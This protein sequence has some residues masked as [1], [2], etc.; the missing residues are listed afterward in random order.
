LASKSADIVMARA[1]PAVFIS[2]AHLDKPLVLRVVEFLRGGGLNV[3]VDSQS[4]PYGDDWRDTLST[5]IEKCE[6]VMLFWTAAASLSKW[7][8]R[9]WE[10]ALEKGKRV[11]PTLL[12]NTPLPP[13]LGRLQAV[14]ALRG[15]FAAPSRTIDE[16]IAELAQRDDLASEQG[17]AGPSTGAG[18]FDVFL[19]N[20]PTNRAEVASSPRSAGSGSRLGIVV[21]SLA[22]VGVL[23]WFLVAQ[24]PSPPTGQIDLPSTAA[25][26]PVDRASAPN[27]IPTPG[28][29]EAASAPASA[30]GASEPA[31]GVGEGSG[32]VPASAPSGS[33]ARESLPDAPA[34]EPGFWDQISPVFVGWMALLGAL[35]LS[36]LWWQVRRSRARRIVDE[37]LSA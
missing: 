1:K 3:F 6:R 25:S 14:T 7:V 26:A 17:D 30:D 28:P 21:A 27:V 20:A 24:R 2:Y 35:G 34:M 32:G 23:T 16:V 15:M 36:Y 29:A 4:I 22:A 11:V 37:L 33:P 5:S 10:L 9:E 8:R 13:T 12:D 31:S 19:R 18:E